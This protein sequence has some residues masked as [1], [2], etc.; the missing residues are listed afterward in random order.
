MG[1]KTLIA[2]QVQGAMKVLG[3]GEDGLAGKHTYIDVQEGTYNPTTRRVS[4]VEERHD[5]VPMMLARFSIDD[6]DDDVRP[7][8]D[9][10]ALIAQL[11]LPVDPKG[12]DKIE[13]SNG[14]IYNVRRVLKDPSEGLCVLH[15]RME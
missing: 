1:F 2:K 8:T 6:M 12:E 9:R 13:L 7:T 5:A 3:T 14:V 10:K 15:I 11:D 4:A